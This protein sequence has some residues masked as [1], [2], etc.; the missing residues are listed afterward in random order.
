[1]WNDTAQSG[2]SDYVNI[3]RFL[4]QSPSIH[5]A[6]CCPIEGNVSLQCSQGSLVAAEVEDFII[7][8]KMILL[9]IMSLFIAEVPGKAFGAF[10]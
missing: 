10:N 2:V 9:K 1:V 6:S 8:L 3:H 4:Q 7:Q 5:L